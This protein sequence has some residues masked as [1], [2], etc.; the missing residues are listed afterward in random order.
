[1]FSDVLTFR[2]Y[3]QIR[4]EDQK[5]LL[6]VRNYFYIL[7]RRKKGSMANEIQREQYL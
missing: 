4:I 2:I 6:I 1:M 3:M 7:S 5:S